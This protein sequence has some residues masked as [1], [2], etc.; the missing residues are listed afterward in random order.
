MNQRRL[1]LI[2]ITEV[3][4]IVVKVVIN[5]ELELGRHNLSNPS[6]QSL[7]RLSKDAERQ[8]FKVG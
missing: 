2:I 1:T 5:P 3:I 4:M 8:I 7:G 6:S